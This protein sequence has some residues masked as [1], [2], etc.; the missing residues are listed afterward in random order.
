VLVLMPHSR[1]NCRCLMCDIWRSNRELR[2]IG[3]EDLEPHIDAMRAW[4][5]RWIVLSGGEALM[6]GNLWALC[7]ALEPLGAKLTLLSTGLLLDRDA[8]QIGKCFDEI[9]VS[10]DGSREVHDRIR[11]IPRAFERL[12]AGVAAVRSASPSLT[13][14]ARSVLQ[15]ENHADFAGTIE[16]AASLK[17]DWI[18][19]LAVDASSEAFNRPG[20][21]RA[22]RSTRVSLTLEE[23]DVLESAITRSFSTHAREYREGFIVESPERLASLVRYFRAIA[24]EGELPEQRCNAPW[25]SAVVEPDGQLRPCFFH[26]PFGNINDEPLRQI[27]NSSQASAFRRGLDINQDPI[28]RRC[29]CPLNL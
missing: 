26:P 9:I 10:L 29:V 11:N 1:C 22:E 15:K 20:G 27:L 19:F 23:C 13:I 21:W 12:A 18:S 16:A 25:V 4:G 7:R 5:V 3:A 24:G 17:L 6:H 28:C 2:E 14:G 8:E